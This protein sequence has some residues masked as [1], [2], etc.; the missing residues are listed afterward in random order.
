MIIFLY[1]EN[2]FKAKQKLNILKNKF[3]Q[4]V[5]PTEQSFNVIDGATADLKEI[6]QL[7][8]TSSLFAK[9]RL[10]LI[11][12]I[13]ANKKTTILEELLDF[14]KN[15][16]LDKADDIIIIYEPKIKTNR[17]QVVKTGA[18][19]KES[20]LNAKEKKLFD[21]LKSQKFSQEFKNP[22]NT[23]LL[24]WVKEE[25]KNRNSAIDFQ[26]TQALI[27]SVGPDLWQLNNEIDKL[28]NYKKLGDIPTSITALDVKKIVAGN[29]DE[30][31]FALTD[32]FSLKQKALALKILEEQFRAGLSEEYILTM[33]TRQF[34]ILLQIKA[35]LEENYAPAKMASALKFHPFVIKKGIDQARNFTME[36]LK[37]ISN[38]LLK[39]DYLNKTGQGEPKT[40]LNLLI[41]EF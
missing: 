3:T 6:S 8:N 17:S 11:E 15:N 2:S 4:E 18:A 34:K 25:F 10:T 28:A 1:G 21:F 38:K 7:V 39:I 32:A 14:L 5:D 31:I 37:D 33:L 35:A 12:N 13:F 26:G 29:F 20:P 23:E 9:K 30:N 40:N 36:Q 16:N 22:T 19:K 27:S 41:S 24:A